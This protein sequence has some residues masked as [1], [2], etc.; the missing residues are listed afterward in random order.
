MNNPSLDVNLSDGLLKV[1]GVGCNGTRVMLFA[2]IV[3]LAFLVL[4]IDPL[5]WSQ[6]HSHHE[7]PGMSM[8]ANEP[9]EG[10]LLD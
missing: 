3:A 1:S 9:T 7:H 2:G 6:Q 8:S 5:A 10:V 4:S